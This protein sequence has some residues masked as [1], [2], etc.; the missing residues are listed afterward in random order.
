MVYYF[1]KTVTY[2]LVNP[3]LCQDPVVF[4]PLNEDD[5][6]QL[7]NILGLPANEPLIGIFDIG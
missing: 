1:H 3:E 4:V 6:S 7:K 2:K 5:R